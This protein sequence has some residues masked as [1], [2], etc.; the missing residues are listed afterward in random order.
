MNTLDI[1]KISN[2]ESE[3][4]FLNSDVMI[5]RELEDST[6]E[7]FEVVEMTN[8]VYYANDDKMKSKRW[9]FTARLMNVNDYTFKRF[10]NKKDATFTIT[11]NSNGIDYQLKSMLASQVSEINYGVVKEYKFVMNIASRALTYDRV[12]QSVS[13]ESS[14]DRY[15]Q[16]EYN[17]A[18]YAGNQEIGKFA[19]NFD[20][21]ADTESYF[22]FMGNGVGDSVRFIVNGNEVTFK[23][24]QLGISDIFEYSNIPLNL[25]LSING[26]RRLDL[27]DLAQQMFAVHTKSGVNSVLIEG[28]QNIEFDIVKGYKII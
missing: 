16:S 6:E 21:D 3:W 12:V 23:L 20:N 15:N 9:S 28:L 13:G 22:S 25:E 5:Q 14:N 17:I 7:V 4:D 2:G 24:D 26:T 19:F 11:V 1:L 8:A 18:K 27:I 10:L